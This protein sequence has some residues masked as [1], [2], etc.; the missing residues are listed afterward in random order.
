ML[1]KSVF[2]ELENFLKKHEIL[3]VTEE[4]HEVPQAGMVAKPLGGMIARPL[5]GNI[6]SKSESPGNASL[7]AFL[8]NQQIFRKILMD[9]LRGFNEKKKSEHKHSEIY[10][11]A[12][13]SKQVFSKIFNGKLPEKDNVIMLAFAL[14]ATLQEAEELLKHSGYSFGDCV[15]RDLIFTFCFQRR[16]FGIPNVN[17]LLEKENENRLGKDIRNRT[18]KLTSLE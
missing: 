18:M 7:D 16:I 11:R 2:K 14:E 6:F 15:K 13:M 17:E 3:W 12:C 9:A 10:K 4:N 8:K 1:S 5:G